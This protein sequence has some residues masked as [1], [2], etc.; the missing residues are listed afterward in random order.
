MYR[1]QSGAKSRSL[2]FFLSSLSSP[3]ETIELEQ[4]RER[5]RQRGALFLVLSRSF[6]FLLFVDPLSGAA[7]TEIS[8]VGRKAGKR[9]EKAGARKKT[10]VPLRL[11]STF[12]SLSLQGPL[13]LQ[14]SVS[15]FFIPYP[16]EVTHR[17]DHWPPFVAFVAAPFV[18]IWGP[19]AWVIKLAPI[20]IGSIGLPLATS[21]TPVCPHSNKEPA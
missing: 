16:R 2:Y 10:V 9:L 18:R 19:E 13:Q 1:E 11:P 8:L 20:L 5:E 3:R 21:P 4:K 6:A 17:E 12:F 7:L 14:Q 15:F